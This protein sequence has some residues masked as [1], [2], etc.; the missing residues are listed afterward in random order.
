MARGMAGKPQQG[1]TQAIQM[2]QLVLLPRL[3]QGVRAGHGIPPVTQ[4]H[5]VTCVDG[6]VDLVARP[7]PCEGLAESEHVRQ[8]DRAHGSRLLDRD[9]M[10]CPGGLICG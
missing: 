8:I 1:Q 6:A 10:R 9:G 7:A 3:H 2:L 5:Q 4:P